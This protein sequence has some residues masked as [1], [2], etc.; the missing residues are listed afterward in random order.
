MPSAFTKNQYALRSV[1]FHRR[2]AFSV[3]LGVAT[4]ATVI[5]GALIVGD[6]MRGSLRALTVDRLGNIDQM[7]IPGGFFATEGIPREIDNRSVVPVILFDRG[8]VETAAVAGQAIRR[9]SSIQIL[10][11]DDSFRNLDPNDVLPSESIGENEIVLN[12]AAADELGVE[13]GDQVTVRLP[14][15]QAV[16]ADSPLGKRD[17]QTEGIPRLTVKT[18][19]DNRGLGRFALHPSQ[20][21]PMTAMLARETIA[22]TLDRSGQANSL[23][24]SR[25]SSNVDAADANWTDSLPH[26]LADFGLKLSRVTK[27][28][29]P[30]GEP[31][32]TIFDYYQV[33]S[34]RLLLPEATS[35]TLL[36]VAGLQGD[37]SPQV[38]MTYLANAIERIDKG[39]EMT[40]SVPYS[41]I[42]AIDSSASMPLDY[43]DAGKLSTIDD[44]NS[45]SSPVPIVIN[46]WTATA[47]EASVGDRLRVA[48]YE[49]E[50]EGGREIEES[51]DAV[52]TAI[53]PIT[54]PS[55]PYV[56]N[57]P[58]QFDSRPTVYNDPDLTPSVPGVTDQDSIS[59]WDLP[60]KLDRKIGTED[61]RYWA[62]HRLTPK[63][64]IP[65]A[66]GQPLFGSRFG[67]TTSIRFPA[68]A[69]PN[70]EELEAKIRQ[71]LLPV[72]DKLGWAPIMI[73]DAQLAASRGTTPFDAL[74]L[75]LSLFVI[76][77]AVMLISLLYRLGML[78][79][80]REYG[81]L[82]AS[83][84]SGKDVSGIAI[85]EGLWSSLPG[86]LL[87]LVGGLGYAWLVLAALRSWWVGAVTVPF[88]EFHATPRSFLIG[89][90]STIAVALLTIWSTARRLRKSTAQSLLSGRVE[91]TETSATIKK[92]P[93]HMGPLIASALLVASVV[94]LVIGG[95]GS[96]LAQA[97]AFVGAG[98]LL[99]TASLFFIHHRLAMPPSRNSGAVHDYTLFKLASGNLRRN[100]LRSTLAIGLMSVA[101]FLIVSIGAFQL[102]PTESG[103]GGFALMARTATPLYRDLNDPV[104]QSELLGQDRDSIPGTQIVSLRLKSGQDASCNNLYQAEQPQV[105]AVP[106]A[107]ADATDRVPFDW[108]KV[109]T[110][111]LIKPDA[112]PWTLLEATA[113]GTADDPIPLVLDQNTA[114]WSLQM[115][116]G[117]GQERSFSWTPDNPIYF[118]IVGLLSNSVLQGSLLI[119]EK[120]FERVFPEVN[121]Y[122]FFMIAT[123]Q[124]ARVE[125][126]LENRLSDVGMDVTQSAVVLSRLMAVQ[127]TYLKTFQSLGALGLLLGTFGLAIAQLR[128]ALERQSELAVL[129]AIGFSKSRLAKTIMIETASLLAIGIGC[130]LACAAIAIAPQAIAGQVLPPIS[131]PILAIAFITVMGL[132]AGLVT[133]ARVIQMPLIESIRSRG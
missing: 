48:Y 122:E 115:T 27:L 25:S 105:L 76:L 57:R 43:G 28:F 67:D 111:D 64:F 53:V 4:A 61:D 55:R 97:G 63:A 93:R 133:V 125:E 54:K 11:I 72:R 3:A 8:V 117:I 82:M 51:F 113:T 39:G 77:A 33:T 22:E 47:L 65:L 116:G 10:G 20:V 68:S 83:G 108:A 71:A 112:S 91:S 50:V 56:R 114:M 103:V 15:E 120:N 1:W 109:K 121:G 119:G 89:G 30:E 62:E 35:Q 17:S 31:A 128:S 44:A 2:L 84:W 7:V 90:V 73:R 18:I 94:A 127:N 87:G 86:V 45:P 80:G 110:D 37:A 66:K 130:G 6:S 123:D 74:F 106:P 101:T 118:R 16:P 85:R 102:S 75:S 49:P 5:T 12:R 19:I 58:N 13:V 38:S 131:A 40:A 96:G 107:M 88:L 95:M 79:R 70:A 42:T 69:A 98:M 24:V 29:T 132:I 104:V 99:L 126:V 100:P 78:Q 92:P 59:D 81:L 41:I 14:S 52:L 23:F 46:D 26:R 32:E 129:R 60:F 124:P 9:A 36:E 21:E 34:D